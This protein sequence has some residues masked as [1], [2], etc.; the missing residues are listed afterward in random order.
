MATTY[1]KPT[2]QD[3]A[4]V[5]TVTI[6]G[7]PQIGDVFNIEINNKT[8][9]F[10]ATV[11][12]TANVVAGLVAAWNASEITE[13]AEITA[14]DDDPDVVLTHDTAGVPFTVTVSKVGTGTIAT[15]TTTAATGR[16]HVDNADNWTE[17]SVP[18]AGDDVYADN[19]DVSMLWGLD[20]IS[21]T[22]ASFNIG[23]SFTGDIGLPKENS[24]GFTE[25]RDDYLQINATVVKIG[26]EDGSG[27]GR[28]K[29]DLGSVQSTITIYNT[30]NSSEDGLA[31][32]LIKGT[33]ASN[34][35]EVL[36]GT[37]MVAAYGGETATIKTLRISGGE[38]VCGAG[39]TL[40]GAGSTIKVGD[41]ELTLNTAF[42]TCRLFGGSTVMR[43]DGGASLLLDRDSTASY[44]GGGTI[45]TVNLYSRLDL[46]ED[47]TN[48]TF[49]TCVLHPGG[50]I[51]D[52]AETLTIGTLTKA[53]GV[54]ELTA[55]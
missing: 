53:V 37:V 1:W 10:T 8:I 13:V 14:A 43:G 42:G 28:I 39:V 2:A 24:A 15:A 52:P 12:T 18:G 5:E 11:A 23:A 30:G 16:N 46:S 7:G 47:V 3:V 51:D 22:L 17:G 6:G 55:G 29:L 45:T 32:V 27:S 50:E 36:D 35:L 40:N 21:G 26:L 4:Q 54:K 38:C 48:R 31:A 44:E 49:T 25:Y 20:G 41:G 33:H 19:T 9:T 34:S